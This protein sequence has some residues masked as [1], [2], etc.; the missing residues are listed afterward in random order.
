MPYKSFDEINQKI[1][2][3]KAVVVTAEEIKRIVEEKGPKVAAKEVDVVTTA[4]FGPMCSTGAFLNFGHSDP[5][6]RMSKVWLNDVP[7]Y[8]GLAAV[9]A[10]IGATELS[11]TRGFD[12]GGAHVIEDLIAGKEIKLRATSYGTDCYPLKEL[13]TCI[14]KDSINQAYMFNPR[15]CYQNYGA[16]TNTSDRT[17]YTYMGTLLPKLGNVNYSTTGELSPLLNDPL[18]RTTGVGTRIFLGGAQGYIA[19]QGTQHNPCQARGENSVPVG[20]AATLALIGDLKQMDTRFIRAAV[21]EK[22]GVTMFVG[23]GIPIPILDEEMASFVGVRDKDIHTNIYDYSVPSRSRPV[24]RKV[25]YEELRSG[26]V[27]IDG[28]RVPTA[29]LSSLKIA[30]EIADLLKAQISSGDFLLQQPAMALPADVRQK[31]LEVVGTAIEE[32]SR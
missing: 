11:E 12:Y 29:P 31:L 16:A 26:S 21:F 5:P 6:I 28:R 18:Y 20:S 17:I 10:F 24:I 4:T 1:R 19:W 32:G 7:A 13:E 3:K 27:A 15:N 8:A 2:D 14:T 25:S 30:R 22:Y 9:D 23:V